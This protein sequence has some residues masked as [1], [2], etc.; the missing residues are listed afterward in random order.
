MLWYVLSGFIA[1]LK[2]LKEL[3]ALFPNVDI[4]TVLFAKKT[5]ELG[6]AEVRTFLS[7]NLLWIGLGIVALF[8]V[9]F[10]FVKIVKAA[11]ASGGAGGGGSGQSGGMG[12]IWRGIGIA[13]FFL[14]VALVAKV[15]MA[16]N[17]DHSAR[18][19]HN[20]HEARMYE[21][22]RAATRATEAAARAQAAA[23]RQVATA[24]P[25]P[26]APSMEIWR[27]LWNPQKYPITLSTNLSVRI[28]RPAD[29]SIR[30]D[31]PGLPYEFWA[32][33]RY[34]KR[35]AVPLMGIPPGTTNVQFRI[36]SPTPTNVVVIVGRE[37]N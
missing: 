16:F 11:K 26:S 10:V 34:V 21:D 4:G 35:T 23:V 32:N 5:T 36:T 37:V 15:F 19:K 13:V 29:F 8:V 18:V 33:G 28:P 22:L 25:T 17:D 1:V 7:G 9:A 12:W 24:T 2:P 14:L 30:V 3:K 31:P 6:S 27:G 20:S